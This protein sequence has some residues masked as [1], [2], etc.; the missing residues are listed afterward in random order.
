MTETTPLAPST[1]EAAAATERLAALVI[2]ALTAIV[3]GASP[4]SSSRRTVGT[5]VGRPGFPINASLNGTAAI[6]LSTG[7][8]VLIRRRRIAAHRAVHDRG[9]RRV[10][11]LPHHLPDPPR[12]GGLGPLPRCGVAAPRLPGASRPAHRAGGAPGAAGVD[13]H[14]PCLARPLRPSPAAGP[15]HAAHPALRP[16]QRRPRVLPPLPLRS[17][18]PVVLGTL[19]AFA[20]DRV[21]VYFAPA[22]RARC[23]DNEASWPYPGPRRT[24]D[25]RLVCRAG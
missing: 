4:S 25:R 12:P 14:P 18:S 1:A 16:G 19:T 11:P 9:L 6:L 22:R 21:F 17:L 7:Y 23:R 15:C 2:G 3:M 13:D 24:H 8:V 10:R 20:G 5:R